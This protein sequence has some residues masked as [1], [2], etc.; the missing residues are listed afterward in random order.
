MGVT[1]ETARAVLIAVIV[2]QMFN[3]GLMGWMFWRF[4]MVLGNIL[5]S[6]VRSSKDHE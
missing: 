3:V 5:E 1:E 6:A 2:S 4:S